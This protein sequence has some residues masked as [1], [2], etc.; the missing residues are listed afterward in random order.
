[1]LVLCQVLG[2][3]YIY[4]CFRNYLFNITKLS[5]LDEIK[6]YTNLRVTSLTQAGAAALLLSRYPELTPKEVKLR[7]RE[8][9][10]DLGEPESIQG[11]G[12]LDIKALL[13]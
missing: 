2:Y 8:T 4:L 11:C 12:M 10:R 3:D 7:L 9:A 1:M 13:S 5:K 6:K